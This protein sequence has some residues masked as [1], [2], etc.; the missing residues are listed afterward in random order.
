MSDVE[1][2]L[3]SQIASDT[4]A[5]RADAGLNPLL[6]FE[7]LA[8]YAGSNG[9]N[10]VQDAALGHSDIVTLIDDF[11]QNMWAAENALVMFDPASDAAG[12][13]LGSAPHAANMMAGR[14]THIWVDVR[15]ADDGRMWVTSQYI[16]RTVETPEDTLPG[17]DS[18]VSDAATSDLRCPRTVGPFD[19]ADRFVQ[20]QYSDFLGRAADP[21]GLAYWAGMLNTEELEPAEV[22]LH[23]LNSGEF[24]GRIRPQAERALLDSETLPTAEQVREWRRTTQSQPR[25]ADAAAIRSEVDVLM[26]YVGMLNRAPDAEGFAY[27]T[28]LAQSGTDLG[29]LVEGF[30]ASDEYRNR[31]R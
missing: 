19:S 27:W 5:V 16:E 24:A 11:P 31:V 30:L 18:A 22:I 12:L 4:N 1:R 7:S 21:E 15:C 29:L 10:M 8:P 13:W 6:E 23:F 20:Q 9:Q 25:V 17:S 28:E 14:A 3:A 2:A 26:I